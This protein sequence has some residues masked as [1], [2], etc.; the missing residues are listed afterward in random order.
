MQI[1]GSY[2]SIEEWEVAVGEQVRSARIALQLDQRQLAE[3]ANVSVGAV[4]NLERGRGS[5]LTTVIAI[6]RALG[7]TEW[8][9]SL[10]PTVAFSPLRLLRDARTSTPKRVRSARLRSETSSS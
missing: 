8:L 2:L 9:E 6:V 4:S 5:S 10:S 1:N 7:R 3:R